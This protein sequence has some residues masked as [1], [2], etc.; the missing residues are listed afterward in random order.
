MK[1]LSSNF[2]ITLR[3]PDLEMI[4]LSDMLGMLRNTLTA[5]DKCL[6]QDGEN[7]SSPIKI[8]LSLKQKT[9]SDYLVPFL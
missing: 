2:F 6:A 8:Q 7:L 3:E 1:A 4:S 9:F 5:N